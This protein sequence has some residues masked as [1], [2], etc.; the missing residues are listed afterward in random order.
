MDQTLLCLAFNVN[1]TRFV[2][3]T[4]ERII[5]Y[6]T[7]TCKCKFVY[8]NVEGG[9]AH[10]MIMNEGG[11]TF[12]VGTGQNK[13]YPKT[14]L[15]VVFQPT[16]SK[17]ATLGYPY[18]IQ[19]IIPRQYLLCVVGNDIINILTV[20]K[21]LQVKEYELEPGTENAVLLSNDPDNP[22]LIYAD[23]NNVGYIVLVL[24]KFIITRKDADAVADGKLEE[25]CILRI[26]AHKNKIRTMALNHNGKQVATCS[27]QGTL[28]RIFDTKTGHKLQE[29]RRGAS[30]TNILDMCFSPEGNYL[31]VIGAQGT[32]HIYSIHAN[33]RILPENQ[34]SSVALFSNILPA[35]FGSEWSF[36]QIK[37]DE[38]W[39]A[40]GL[41]VAFGKEETS[42]ILVIN[43]GKYVKYIIKPDQKR[44]EKYKEDFWYNP[45]L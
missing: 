12:F 40:S 17:M 41:H 37:I 4:N 33:G 14:T 3:G 9:V 1:K 42:L 27:H 25:E 18:E 30:P 10:A 22:V 15:N 26:S 38:S 7:D 2:V 34:K 13:S 24:F 8:D 39:I 44:I 11:L 35:Y 29:V 20:P 19:R 21:F 36:A 45:I 16:N 6:D 43:N 31:A 23:K 32:L 5:V 28:I